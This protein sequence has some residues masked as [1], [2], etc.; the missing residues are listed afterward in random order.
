[1]EDGQ[2]LDGILIANEVIHTT[3]RYMRMVCY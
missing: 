3:T 1:M 2:I